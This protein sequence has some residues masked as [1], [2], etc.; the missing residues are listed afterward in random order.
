MDISALISASLGKQPA[1]LLVTDARIVN[2]FSGEIVK[3]HIAVSG[4][5]IAGIGD[6]P[7]GRS[8]SVNGRFVLPGF[9]D[10]HVH[11]EST[12]SGVSGF[13]RAVLPHGTTT[14]VADP[15]EIANVL[16]TDG[17]AW[18]LAAAEKQ[19][20]NIF[21]TLPSCV[22]ATGMETAG[23]VL[24][25]P[26]LMP[27]FSH[28]RILAL[29]EMM[30]FAGVIGRDPDV[31]EKIKAAADHHKPVDG[32]A[33]GLSGKALSA[34]LAAGIASDHECVSVRE[35][36]EKLRGGMHI[37]IREATGARN[38][39][40]LLPMVNAATAGR[41]MWCTDDRHPAD[42]LERG[43]IDGIL[44]RA[45][46]GGVDPVTAVR[47]A[48]LNPAAYFGLH[49]LG[50]VAPGRRADLVVT[51]DLERFDIEAVYCAGEL[52][53]EKGEVTASAR[54]TDPETCPDS[55]HVRRDALDFRVP[56]R[57]ES[58]RVIGVSPGSIITSQQV[59]PAKIEA[60]AA[61]SDT[62]RDMIKLA[63]V[64]RHRAT[65]NIGLGF[66]SGFGIR[67]GAIAG[68]I[69]HD[70][71]NIIAAGVDDADLKAAVEAVI[72][73][74]GGMVAVRGG[75]IEAFLALPVAG[76]MSTLSLEKV[77]EKASLL[78]RAAAKMGS[79]LSDPFMT[80]SFLALPVIPELKLTDRGLFDV[81]GFTHVPLFVN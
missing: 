18:M 66:V 22:P 58:V 54:T 65:G 14:V 31:L 3:G 42:I 30:N 32:H 79:V 34:Y 70:S 20:M 7:A 26:A 40:D 52:A 49:R 16:G 62:G 48:T 6:Y 46:S 21:F 29:G 56:A 71:H 33:P 38:L 36:L 51:P 39:D 73:M 60:G 75:R 74:G 28:E 5:Y 1:D 68:S 44:Q 4:G 27:L 57:G 81:S 63:V 24:D 35:A 25:A 45:V 9:I 59:M 12:M 80:L 47:M 77:A 64:E 50:A 15:H 67:T 61:V 13:A 17:I 23:A 72:D 69:A 53:A 37:M 8:V 11:I 43:H 55:I 76:L 10:P 41:L 78:N 19:A 2:V